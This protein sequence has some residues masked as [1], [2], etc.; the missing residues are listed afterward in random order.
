MFNLF[1]YSLIWAGL[2]MRF[3]VS[4]IICAFFSFLFSSS[5]LAESRIALV[6]GNGD[7]ESGAK[8]DNPANDAELMARTLTGAGFEVTKVVDASRF[9]M[10][11]AM[12]EYSRRLSGPKTIGVFYSAGHG[13]QVDGQNYLLPI[14]QI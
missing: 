8:L 6:I 12:L 5:V 7:Y 3:M 13:L 11:K 2:M 9:E 1:L 10:R 14:E 4:F